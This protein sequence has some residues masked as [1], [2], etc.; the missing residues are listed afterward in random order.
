MSVIH[1]AKLHS[2]KLH[3]AKLHSAKLHSAKLHSAKLHSAKLTSAKLHSAKCLYVIWP[4]KQKVHVLQ[5]EGMSLSWLANGLIL[6]ALRKMGENLKVFWA[7]FST[8]SQ[9]VCVMSVIAWK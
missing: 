1:S 7:E 9:A 5:Q 4:K 3:S 8:L 2:A 6:G